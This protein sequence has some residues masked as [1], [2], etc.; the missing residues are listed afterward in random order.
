[1]GSKYEQRLLAFVADVCELARV[2]KPEVSET[3]GRVCAEL[4]A[5][6]ANPDLEARYAFVLQLRRDYTLPVEKVLYPRTEIDKPLELFQPTMEL[7]QAYWRAMGREYHDPD[8]FPRLPPGSQVR[9]QRKALQSRDLVKG[10]L[11]HVGWPNSKGVWVVEDLCG[12]DVDGV[13]LY[14]VEREDWTDGT[15]VRQT[16]L[17]PADE[18]PVE[19]GGSPSMANVRIP[20]QDASLPPVEI[21]LPETLMR[22]EPFDVHLASAFLSLLAAS[23]VGTSRLEVDPHNRFVGTPIPALKPF[24]SQVSGARQLNA[25]VTQVKMM[26]FPPRSPG[27]MGSLRCVIQG[28]LTEFEISERRGK[29]AVDWQIVRRSLP[30]QHP[31]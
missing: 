28:S 10:T 22:G 30:G 5:T 2:V 15:L 17:L 19:P 9:M 31:L 7:L 11:T 29:S 20:T 21:L 25:F 16:A 13:P 24:L 4:S 6:F 18:G 1:M 23:D 14:W 3:L 26:L 12:W 8:S 27:A